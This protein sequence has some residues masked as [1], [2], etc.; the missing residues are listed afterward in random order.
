MFK[1][2]SENYKILL[3]EIREELNKWGNIQFHGTEYQIFQNSCRF[4]VIQM[5]ILA[6][7]YC[8]N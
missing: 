8:R 5:E 2:Y 1:M 3:R 4:S 6:G 7:Y